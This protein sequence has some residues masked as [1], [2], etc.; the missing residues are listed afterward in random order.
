M[1][2]ETAWLGARRC[3]MARRSR[4]RPP[5]VDPLEGRILLSTLVPD[6]EPNNAPMTAIEVALD[7]ADQAADVLGRLR[8][9]DRDFFR[10]ESAGAGTLALTGVSFGRPAR[11]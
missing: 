5:R 10:V 8:G 6:R 1:H 2:N 11:I 4:C 7:P 9:V 3:F